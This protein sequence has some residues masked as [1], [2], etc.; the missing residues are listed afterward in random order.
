MLYLQA[1]DLALGLAALVKNGYQSLPAAI[2]VFA[3]I[4]TFNNRQYAKR[5][6]LATQVDVA[7]KEESFKIKPRL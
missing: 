2:L 7:D 6:C 5:Q 1:P 4:C 3:A